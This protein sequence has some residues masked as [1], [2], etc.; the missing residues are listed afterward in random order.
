ML[1]ES[2]LKR[3][4]GSKIDIGGVEYHF[5]ADATGAHVCDVT[6]EDHLARFLAIPEGFRLVG[7][8][9]APKAAE[10]SED[11]DKEPETGLVITDGETRVD[12]MEMGKKA[13][14]EF[15]KGKFKVDAMASAQALRESIFK[16]AQEGDD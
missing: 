14:L 6:D 11:D 7:A 2:K 1:I 8:V 9:E 15:A 3:K 4:D 10:T 5:K 16:Q 13:L 12:L